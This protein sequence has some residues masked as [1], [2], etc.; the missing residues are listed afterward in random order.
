MSPPE[1][2]VRPATAADLP[3]VAAIY[4]HY[5][6]HSVATF[7]EVPPTVDDWRR[8]LDELTGRG[9]PFL[10]AAEGD[11]VA[12]YTY[13]GPWRPKPA[14]RHTVE[15][16]IYI[17]PGR[18]GR[19]LG[20]LLLGAL[21][22][23]LEKTDTRQVIAVIADTGSGASEALHRHFGFSPAGR[24]TGVGHKHD[25]WIDTSLMQRDLTTT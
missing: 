25:R 2:A 22:T 5:V 12:G 18:T 17:A 9:L 6:A 4:E 24:L 7:E 19:G 14:Y 11:E 21:L 1:M 13:A 8:R 15:D 23:D 20:R 3:A 16:T 10:V